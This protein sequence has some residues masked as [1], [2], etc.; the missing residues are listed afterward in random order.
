MYEQFVPSDFVLETLC[1]P[2]LGKARPTVFKPYCEY[3]NKAFL[4]LARDE[5]I[6]DRRLSLLSVNPLGFPLATV[7]MNSSSDKI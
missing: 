1:S 5:M 7:C 2:R 4:R 3:K 6:M